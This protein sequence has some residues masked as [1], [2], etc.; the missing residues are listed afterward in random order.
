[1]INHALSLC[2]ALT[3]AVWLALMTGD[4]AAAE[5]SIDMLLD[6]SARHA[7]ASW[8]AFG[9]GLQG[10]LAIRRGDVGTGLPLLRTTL[11]EGGATRLA[12]FRLV[13]LLM[14]EALSRAGQIAEGLAAVEDA[15]TRMERSEE[16]WAIAELLHIKGELLLSRGRLESAA[17]AEDHFRRALDWARRQGALSWE[18]RAATSLA[19]L[20]CDQGRPAEAQALL[21]PV[22][23]QFTEG[24]ETADLKMA[25]ALL[26]GLRDPAKRS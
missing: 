5:R 13:P 4:L 20:L 7:L 21:Q 14:A 2:H 18:L 8:H 25:E 9:R 17:L 16:L 26:G 19:R 11:D 3:Q 12:G 22:F 6:H 15:L 1:V 23:D 10:A 24:L